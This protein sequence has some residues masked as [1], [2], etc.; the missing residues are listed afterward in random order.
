MV[1][2]LLL[3][4]PENAIS[5]AIYKKIQKKLEKIKLEEYNSAV[6]VYLSLGSKHVVKILMKLI[7]KVA[8]FVNSNDIEDI[9]VDILDVIKILEY[10][11]AAIH[12][13]SQ[14]M[15]SEVNQELNNSEFNISVDEQPPQVSENERSPST[16][17]KFEKSAIGNK[18]SK[19][20]ADFD[21]DD[22]YT[23]KL[24][25]ELMIVRPDKAKGQ[26]AKYEDVTIEY[27]LNTS[28]ISFTNKNKAVESGTLKEV[29]WITKNMINIELVL[30]EG[31]SKIIK[32]KENSDVAK[33]VEPVCM[34]IEKGKK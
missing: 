1:L 11:K 15:A 19:I 21:N 26:K 10:K 17:K 33:W 4:L 7:K 34:N 28:K 14:A 9:E 25:S 24:Q 2:K 23:L 13:R 27:F 32:L 8:G 16:K 18:M 29:K 5:H 30:E 12:V 3:F 20:L 31:R 22:S 6:G